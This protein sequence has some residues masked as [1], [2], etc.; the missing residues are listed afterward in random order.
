[1]AEKDTYLKLL[2]QTLSAGALMPF[3]IDG[4]DLE[5]HLPTEMPASALRIDTAW[6]MQDGSVFHLEYQNARESSLYR[7][8]NYDTR[9][10]TRYETTVRTVVLYHG[11]VRSAPSTL[12]G[13]TIRYQVENVY[14]AEYDGDAELDRVE[15]HLTAGSWEPGDRLRLALALNMR[16]VNRSQTFERML[17]L[18]HRVPGPEEIDLMMAAG[19]A[20]AQSTLTDGE[21]E[22]LRK[23]LKMVSKIAEELY[24]DG[25]AQGRRDGL[26]EGRQAGRSEGQFVTQLAIAKTMLTAGE[27]VET[28][29]AYTGLTRVQVE[30]LRTTDDP[31]KG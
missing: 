2:S 25:I 5:D 13:G 11:A 17:D 1:M 3:G 14:L 6:R 30:A 15:Q 8:L 21:R 16:V 7:F 10:A 4:V 12:N 23:E 31:P 9:L 19:M 27:S 20:S 29:V 28:I 24:Q 18:I 22:R 26:E